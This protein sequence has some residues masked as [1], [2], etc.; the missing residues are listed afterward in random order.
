MRMR[1]GVSGVRRWGVRIR[2]VRELLWWVHPGRDQMRR[3]WL[4]YTV[5]RWNIIRVILMRLRLRLRLRL[6]GD[7]R[8]SRGDCWLENGY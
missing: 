7:V 3:G 5:R 6:E 4:W 8:I 2:A 1:M